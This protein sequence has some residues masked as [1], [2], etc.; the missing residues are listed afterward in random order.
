MW[1]FLVFLVSLPAVTTRIY[2]TDE[3][4]Y[5]AYLRSLWFD[6]DVSF[7]N[8]Y[9]YFHD[10]G[11]ARAHGFAETHLERTTATG[12]RLNF[13]TVG[14]AILWSPFY[15]LADLYV[16]TA[17]A[18]GREI[19]RDGYSKPYIVAVCYGSL[20]YG[21]LA[22]LLSIHAASR[23][24]ND[25]SA[26]VAGG[27]V[28]WIGTP[29]LFY[30]YVAPVMAHA[31]AAF[32]V[33][34]FIVI[35]LRVRAEWRLGGIAVLAVA[36]AL[37][38][39]VREQDITYIAAPAIDYLWT[40]RK[41]G[42]A[43]SK[44]VVSAI[45]VGAVAFGIAYLPQALSY[46]QLN[47]GVRPEG[48]VM[49]KMNWASPHAFKVLADPEHGFFFWTPLGL[50]AF[51]GVIVLGWMLWNGRITTAEPAPQALGIALVVMLAGQVYILGSLG[52]WSAAGAF[53]QRRFV[54][55]SALLVLGIATLVHLAAHTRARVP[56]IAAF[57]LCIWW[58][59]AFSALFG[60]GM[61][62]RQRIELGRNAYDAFVTLPLQAPSLAYRYFT[63]RQSFYRPAQQP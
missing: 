28:V 13:G 45:A 42:A 35:W 16:V 41:R 23:V 40:L 33:A 38:V 51:A 47:G 4:Q 26:A 53:G 21:L 57:V 58:N 46:V 43:Q 14:S 11:I 32:M 9:R 12:L 50:I 44:A 10:A 30:M 31:T 29:L 24:V 17:N 7:E 48:S 49:N 6:R 36:G 15:A 61:M 5:F 56:L 27:L 25:R 2:A 62:D 1:A 3:V 39:M 63:D 52:T 34:L 60:T 19:P 20:V 18:M 8:E 55:A 54:G 22:V 59:L 37:M